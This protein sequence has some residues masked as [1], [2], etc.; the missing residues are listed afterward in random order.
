LGS[1]YSDDVPVPEDEPESMEELDISD[2]EATQTVDWEDP[3]RVTSFG[4][5]VKKDKIRQQE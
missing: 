3:G 5:V 1:S 2:E 4:M